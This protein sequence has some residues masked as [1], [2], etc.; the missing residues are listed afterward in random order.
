MVRSDAAWLPLAA[1]PSYNTVVASCSLATHHDQEP[2]RRFH[3]VL[4]TCRAWW[5]LPAAGLAACFHGE[6]LPRR[7][8]RRPLDLYFQSFAEHRISPDDWRPLDRIWVWFLPDEERPAGASLDRR[9]SFFRE[10]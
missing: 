7:K 6:T 8:G 5:S 1:A 4:P 2:G 9:L 3:L 10:I